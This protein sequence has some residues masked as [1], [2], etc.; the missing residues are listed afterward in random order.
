MAPSFAVCGARAGHGKTLTSWHG[1][2]RRFDPAA[3]SPPVLAWGN[4]LPR[5][6]RVRWLLLLGLL[7]LPTKAWAQTTPQAPVPVDVTA[8]TLPTVP[9]GQCLALDPGELTISV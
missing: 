9:S 2:R 6:C 8:V 5:R 4:P 3:R 1:R 7:L